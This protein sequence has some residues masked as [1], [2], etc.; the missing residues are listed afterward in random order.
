[1]KFTTVTVTTTLALLGAM[2]HRVG[3]ND[4]DRRRV[5]DVRHR[6]GS[7]ALS[8][9]FFFLLSLLAHNSISFLL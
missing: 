5:Q 2:V 1:M 3:A 8:I 6:G 4:I 7:L 9:F